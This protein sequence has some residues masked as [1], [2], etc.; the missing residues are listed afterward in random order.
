VAEGC[1]CDRPA[2]VL[3]TDE[4]DVI[5]PGVGEEYLVEM[6]FTRELAKRANLDSR[7]IEGDDK[8]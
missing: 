8:V 1:H 5:H 7:L 3:P 6:S 4:I 2:V